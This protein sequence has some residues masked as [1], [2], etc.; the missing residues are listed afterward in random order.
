MRNQ[1]FLEQGGLTFNT[2]VGDEETN[3]LMINVG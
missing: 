3:D 1:S 2:T